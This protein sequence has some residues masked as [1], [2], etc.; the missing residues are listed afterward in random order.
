MI[1]KGFLPLGAML[2]CYYDRSLNIQAAEQALS[3]CGWDTCVVL[4][5]MFR[6]FRSHS[7]LENE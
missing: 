2:A 6:T 1:F 3:C 7:M 4:L 5:P